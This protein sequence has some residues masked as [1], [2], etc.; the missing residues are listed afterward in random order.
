MTNSKDTITRQD[1]QI[2]AIGLNALKEEVDSKIQLFLTALVWGIRS[3]L[4]EAEQSRQV[5]NVPALPIIVDHEEPLEAQS[6]QLP[7][8]PSNQP[9]D[10]E[11]WPSLR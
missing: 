8:F 3:E 5:R 4:E 6:V 10:D 7:L 9:C 11:F 1:I 2:A